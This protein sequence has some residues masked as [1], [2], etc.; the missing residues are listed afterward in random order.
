[1]RALPI[2]VPK[3]MLSTMASGDVRPYVGPSDICMMYSV[4]DVQGRASTASAKRCWPM[5]H[6][7]W[8]AW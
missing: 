7:R 4:T 5:P 1:M 8:P 6:T 3:V 2:G